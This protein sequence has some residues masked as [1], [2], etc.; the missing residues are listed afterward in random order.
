M[1][2][3]QDFMGL[4]FPPRCP[5]CDKLLTVSE[6]RSGEKIHEDCR[7]RLYPLKQPYCMHC[8]RPLPDKEQEY[9][10][11]CTKRLE[12]TKKPDWDGTPFSYITEGKSLFVYQG[13]IRQT[14]YRFKYSNRRKYADF[15]AEEAY[16][17]YG[18]WILQNQIEA[19]IPVPM[20]KKKEKRRGYNQAKLFAKALGAYLGL[21]YEPDAV[22]RLVDTKPQKKLNAEERKNNL[23]NTF[24]AEDFVVKYKCVL[25]VDDI[26]TTGVTAETVAKELCSAGISKIFFLSVCTGRGV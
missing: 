3:K 1:K 10:S 24:H 9:C 17:K 6:I 2:I 25:L 5:L 11:D 18:N 4:L 14:M 13:D 12:Q 26:Y 15:L 22:R 20:Y 19:V 21:A 7:K 16:K 8:G 23:K